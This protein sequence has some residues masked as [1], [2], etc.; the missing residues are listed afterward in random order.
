MFYPNRRDVLIGLGA[1][2][3]RTAVGGPS[4]NLYGMTEST[5][6]Q[7]KTGENDM[8]TVTTKDGAQIFYKDWGPKDAQPI[9]FHHG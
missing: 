2:A 6:T 1:L 7:P 4:S 3:A 9:V 5:A 8:P